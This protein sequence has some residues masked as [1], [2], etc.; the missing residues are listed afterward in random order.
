MRIIILLSTY[1]PVSVSDTSHVSAAIKKN[2]N[3]F[4]LCVCVFPPGCDLPKKKDNL[5]LF[6]IILQ[7]S[8]SLNLDHFYKH[9]CQQILIEKFLCIYYV[10]PLDALKNNSE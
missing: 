10:N 8:F 3:L 9:V 5:G 1:Y 6:V 7:S 4:P 2:H